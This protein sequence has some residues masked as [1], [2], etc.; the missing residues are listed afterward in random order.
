MKRIFVTIL[1]LHLLFPVFVSAQIWIN[2]LMQSN[3]N[4][5]RDDLQEFPDSW[6]ELYNDS[7]EAVDIRNWTVSDNP[8][9]RQGWKITRSVII[10][11]GEYLLIYADKA[12]TDLHTDF[13]LDSGNDTEVYLFN[14][15]GLQMD[16]VTN[17]PAQPAPNIAYGR[18]DD[19]N[20]SW[21][22][23]VTATPGA[24][25]TGK[26]SN[27]LLPPPVFSRKGG[28]FANSVKVSLSLPAGVPANINVSHI[29][30][31]LDNSE[32]TLASPV[33]AG[34]LNIS[35]TTVVRAKL[36]H[37]D[38]LSNWSEVH[39][40]I[41]S[42]QD[43]PL[44]VISIS[45]NPAYLWDDEFGIYCKGNG[46]YGVSGLGSDEPVNWNNNWRRPANFEYFPQESNSS[47]LNQ[48]CEMRICGGWS[49]TNA[50]KSF[51]IYGNKRFGE[52]RF[53]HD[54]FEEKPNQEI[55]SFMIRNAGNDFWCTHFRD[56]AI[57]LF[58]GGKVD[59]DYQ[60]YQ[61]A[62]LFLNGNYWGIQN[63]RERSNEDFVL[64]NYATEDIDMLENWWD[65]KVGDMLAFNQLK[66][67]MRKPASQR[68]NQWIM[69]QIDTDEFINYM[70]LQ[71]YVAN[72]DFLS[73]YNNN[74]VLWRPRRANGKWR[75]ILK[76]TD[77]GLGIWNNNPATYNA[78]DSLY[79]NDTWNL[80]NIL[81]TQDSFKKDFYGRFA[82]YMGDLL[83]YSS[84]A[85]IIDSLQT[86][87]EPAM[88]GHLEFWQNHGLS[89]YGISNVWWR[90]MNSWRWEVSLM[91]NWCNK[92][93]VEVY[94][95]LRNY[96]KL[97][98]IM[99][100]TYE[101]AN[102]LTGNPAVF[103]NGVRMR[104]S[105]L[106]ASYFQSEALELHYDGDAPLYGWEITKTVGGITTVE[107]YFRQD[108]SYPIAAGC[109]SVEIKLVDNP[110]S[111]SNPVLPEI[112]ASVF[113]GQLH[114]ANVQHPSVISVYDMSGKLLAQ[115]S[116][117]KSSV[118]IPL[119]QK[120][121]LIVK[122]QHEGQ[123]FTQ[124]IVN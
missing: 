40:Y 42:E 124:K 89:G 28:V 29:H 12:A 11:P 13:R 24:E 49:R 67:E 51:I 22:Y 68:D 59:I 19:G 32:P 64:A 79:S 100:L 1:F 20:V 41:I 17:V 46:K 39:T 18:I 10:P 16:G 45:V 110:N 4:L 87:I 35:K 107:T 30:Y 43:F 120:G 27:K 102:D 106:D 3:I 117:T 76:D 52:K 97:G 57:Q 114:I 95:H 8:D 62:I 50:Q 54:L 69:K 103:I 111:L 63:L 80:F 14:A 55:K 37:P 38:Y 23:F 86:L 6:I 88:P 56:A 123:L 74:T 72:T 99:Q 66:N 26:T 36:L 92:R 122:I 21:A 119:R 34:E 105:G 121:I 15:S 91:K 108:V 118:I 115:T 7:D 93:N 98:T 2:E 113:N 85:H 73:D 96:F 116:A 9:Y 71:I 84:T 75:F 90:D 101:P 61:P 94:K 78:L 25:N 33:Y 53:N 109:T 31:T 65:I 83:H 112:T 77:H 70:I 104:D 44:P 81:L 47:V 48:L 5:V 60:A 82:V 58:F